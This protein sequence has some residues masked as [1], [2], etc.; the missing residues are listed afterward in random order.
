[1]AFDF[2]V[3]VIGSGF[4]AAVAAI[5][6]AK[7][8][9]T[10]F[11]LERGVWWLTPELSA[12]NPMN[13]FLKT[14]PVQYWPRPD[15]RR[16]LIDFL[17]VV[18]ANGVAGALQDFA[19]GV[20]EFFTGKERPK[21]LYRYNTFDD[22]D[23]ISA[24]GVGGGSLI[25]SNVT[26]GPFFDKDTNQYPAMASWPDKAK[27]LP[28]NYAE[29]LNWMI[30]N[31]GTPNQVVTK[32]PQAIP[33]NQLNTIN[34]SDPRLLG[35]SRFLRDASNGVSPQLAE[36]I[37]EPWAPL[38]LQIKEAD[39]ANLA[40]NKNFC[41]RQG[42][43]FLGCLPAARH[44]LNKT[45]LN[46][47][48]LA[49]Q[50]KVL[51]RPLA[52]V[53]WIEAMPGGG[54]TVHYTGLEDGS[55]FHPTAETVV[56]AAGCLGSTEILL[57][58]RDKNGGKLVVS[59]TLGSKFSTNGDFSGF[60]TVDPSKL[61]YPIYATR[62]PINTSHVAFRDGKLLVNVE[63]AGIPAMFASLVEKTL[64][65]LEQ[66]NGQADVIDMLGLLWNKAELPDY[67]DPNDMQTEAEMLMNTCWFNCMG[68]DDATGVFTLDGDDLQLK[69][70][71]A[72]AKHPTFQKA[73]SIL[74]ELAKAMNG[75]YRAFPLWHG[76]E[77]FVSKKLVVV[78]PLGGCPI[79]GS[80]TDGVVNSNGQVY[81]TTA[82]A[83]T[84][85]DGL[86]VLDAS[87]IPG[88]VAVNPTL[89]IVSM[90]ARAVK[91]IA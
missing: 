16:G 73:E 10:V 61:Q 30:V 79:G 55:E 24:S 48:P 26:I 81:N 74:Q 91:S 9:K 12:E 1:M 56:L 5:D 3:I 89:S 52:N 71:S 23:V 8:G 76:L 36:Q 22:A 47:L 57:R 34:S 65:M 7:K 87:I 90:V 15:H 66:D 80:S 70:T 25:Y 11:I 6:Q 19:N 86:Y 40:T 85:H 68:I 50:D 2:Q 72:I 29:G 45:L 64:K 78:H 75:S 41:E 18:K 42:R 46:Q 14:Q 82:G 58:S 88:A 17:A 49:A 32:Y 77:P 84:V 27:L 63:D 31:R 67:S 38:K 54:Y 60:V 28:A 21:P 69:F 4:G 62:G 39:P 13:P 37:V 43:C 59:K 83:E 53:E 44:T 51:I 35:R 20:A 33:Q